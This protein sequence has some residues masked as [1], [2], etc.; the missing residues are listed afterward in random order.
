MNTAIAHIPASWGEPGHN[1]PPEPTPFDLSKQ[2]IDDLYAEAQNWLDGDPITTPEQAEAVD[3][4]RNLLREAMKTADRRRV[5]ENKPFDDG[6]AEVQARYAPLIADT[7]TTKGKAVTAIALCGEALLPYLKR[8]E[9]ENRAKAEAARREAEEKSAAAQASFRES[10]AADL[11][12]RERAEALAAEAAKAERAASKAE[13]TK[14]HVHGGARATGLRTKTVVTVT[15]ET[16]FA[17]HVW[18]HHREEMSEFLASLATRLVNAKF[19]GL[20][21]V[22]VELERVI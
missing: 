20:P 18:T 15:D 12:A 1:N 11:A 9:E 7:K 13:N 5:E 17:K 6:K 8:V 10:A 14:A 2:E 4:L 3:K 16:A 22:K 21:G 19:S